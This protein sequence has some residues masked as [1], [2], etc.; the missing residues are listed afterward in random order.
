MEEKYGDVKILFNKKFKDNAKEYKV[1][2]LVEN[3]LIIGEATTVL[4]SWN[5]NKVE[6]LKEFGLVNPRL[7]FFVLEVNL[8]VEE[9]PGIVQG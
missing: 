6:K 8:D 7:Y 5:I 2:I 3:P 1:D 9:S 4:G